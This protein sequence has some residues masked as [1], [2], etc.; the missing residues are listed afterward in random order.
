[1]KA[2]S[3]IEIQLALF[4][5]L[6]S[7]GRTLIL[8]N[9]TPYRWH[10]C[11]LFSLTRALYFH[12]IEVKISRTDFLVDF[13]KEEKHQALAQRP[14]TEEEREWY[15]GVGHYHTFLDASPRTFCYACPENLLYPKDIPGYAGLLY[16]GCDYGITIIKK[17]P[18]LPGQKM[19]VEQV[20]KITNNLWWKFARTWKQVAEEKIR[21]GGKE[22]EGL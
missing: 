14:L 8:P 9:F 6:E 18:M 10:E 21:H 22:A 19:T 5:W 17:P 7:R 15:D 13:K 2:W 12:E 11:D 3:E 16:V 20:F 4:R 1:M